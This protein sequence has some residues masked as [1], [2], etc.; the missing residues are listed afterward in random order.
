MTSPTSST[1]RSCARRS[2]PS[3]AGSNQCGEAVKTFRRCVSVGTGADRIEVLQNPVLPPLAPMSAMRLRAP[4]GLA[5]L[6]ALLVSGCGSS[7]SASDNATGQAQAE[8]RKFLRDYVQ[9]D[10]EVVRFDQGGDTVSEGQAY[11][12]LLSVAA[13][14][15]DHVRPGLALGGHATCSAPDGLLAWQYAG[16]RVVDPQPASDA[17][18][19]TAWALDLAA[20]RFAAPAYERGQSACPQGHSGRRGCRRSVIVA[21][22][23]AVQQMTVNP[24]YWTPA[25][26]DRFAR[27]R[28]PLG[29]GGRRDARARR[30]GNRRTAGGCPRTGAGL[31]SPSPASRSLRLHLPSGAGS[32]IY[33]LDAARLPVWVS[34]LLPARRASAGRC[35]AAVDRNRPGHGGDRPQAT[36]TARPPR[37]TVSR[38]RSW[39][40]QPQRAR[41]GTRPLGTSSSTRRTSSPMNCP[42]TTP[43]PG[44]PSAACCCR[45]P[46]WR[47]ARSEPPGGR[48]QSS[49]CRGRTARSGRRP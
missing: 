34:H 41:A 37:P 4:V 43:G 38:W 12:M 17:D 23:W 9:P 35:S 45:L 5:V 20:R 25:A 10:G 27:R 13:G 8:A 42:A 6:L 47:T 31:R 22:P 24:S 29:A 32:I 7:S 18:L 28:P 14:D 21:G 40:P 33:S 46:C 2:I 11:A 3:R 48:G 16:G 26:M 49:G 36:W 44:L 15:R 19:L 1:R 39:Q 30:R